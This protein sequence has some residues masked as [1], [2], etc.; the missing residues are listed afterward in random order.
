MRYSAM[1]SGRHRC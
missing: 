1:S